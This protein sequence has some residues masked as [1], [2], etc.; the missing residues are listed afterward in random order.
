MKPPAAE[1]PPRLRAEDIPVWLEVRNKSD[2]EGQA[3][4]NPTI[5]VIGV[6]FHGS[7]IAADAIRVQPYFYSF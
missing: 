6:K 2:K 7:I 4:I 1:Y 5:I 3:L